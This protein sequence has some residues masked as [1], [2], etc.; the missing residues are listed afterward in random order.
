MPSS[1]PLSAT[2]SPHF[3][4]CRGR[5]QRLGQA[6]SRASR[7]QRGVALI[8]AL[9][10]ILIFSFGV[11]G[12]L[13]LEAQAINFSVNAEDRTRAALFASEIA[14]YLWVNNTVTPTAAQKTIWSNNI[15]LANNTQGGLNAGT[16]AVNTVGPPTTANSADIIITWKQQSDPTSAVVTQTLTTRV[17]IPSL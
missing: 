17:T 5:A 12:L 3:V 16:V 4:S 13:G 10:S 6:K 15:L 1:D 11:L 8:E 14:S 9:V 7:G 2:T